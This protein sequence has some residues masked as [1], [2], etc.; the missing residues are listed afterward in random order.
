MPWKYIDVTT[1]K[2]RMLLQMLTLT[3]NIRTSAPLTSADYIRSLPVVTS[4]FYMC[5][6]AVSH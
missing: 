6:L 1:V 2:M 3:R 4:A 5:P